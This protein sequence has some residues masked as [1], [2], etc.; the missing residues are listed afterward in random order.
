MKT[1]LLQIRGSAETLIR[2]LDQ[3]DSQYEDISEAAAKKLK[4]ALADVEAE[5]GSFGEDF[6]L[7]EMATMKKQ[8]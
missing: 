1:S 6:L 3:K 4:E 5:L 7:T 8:I 2:R